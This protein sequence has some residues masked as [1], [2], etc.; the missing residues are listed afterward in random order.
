M[1]RC[2]DPSRCSA[3][4]K[5]EGPSRGRS[6][7]VLRMTAFSPHSGWRPF[8]LRCPPEGV[9]RRIFRAAEVGSFAE[10]IHRGARRQGGWKGLRGEDP[11]LRSATS[12]PQDSAERS[13]AGAKSKERCRL[14]GISNA[15][16][17][18]RAEC[19]RDGRGRV[20]QLGLRRPAFRWTAVKV[21]P[22]VPSPG[23]HAHP[24]RKSRT[25]RSSAGSVAPVPAL[26]QQGLCRRRCRHSGHIRV[27]GYPAHHHLRMCANVT[28]QGIPLHETR[29]T[30]RC[31]VFQQRVAM[32]RNGR[33]GRQ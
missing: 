18:G 27:D 21:F 24:P 13:A 29:G 10:K 4:R 1:L 12:A 19:Q 25:A 6:F 26:L 11:S 2:A 16:T 5:V 31:P 9:A 23:P 14:P 15:P 30:P 3:T 8:H 17:Q 22:R 20:R 7:A 28:Q 33:Q 32:G